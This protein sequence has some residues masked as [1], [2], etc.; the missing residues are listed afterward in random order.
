MRGAKRKGGGEDKNTNNTALSLL[1]SGTFCRE[2]SRRTAHVCVSAGR[3]CS[4][5]VVVLRKQR[6][7]VTDPN[8][9]TQSV[10]ERQLPEAASQDDALCCNL[11]QRVT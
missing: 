6:P 10:L 8:S 9:V 7:S 3:W 1:L 5:V 2:S 4:M 11:R